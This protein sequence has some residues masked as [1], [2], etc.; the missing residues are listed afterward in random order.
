MNYSSLRLQLLRMMH[1]DQMAIKT[2]AKFRIVTENN[3]EKLKDI[4]FKYGWPTI[5]IVGKQACEAA[6]LIAQHAD[7][8]VVFQKKCLQLI[9]FSLKKGDVPRYHYAYLYDRICANTGSPYQRFGTQIRIDKSKI[10]EPYPPTRLHTKKLDV[11]RR[12][13]DLPPLEEYLF[14]L[15]S[16]NSKK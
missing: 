10:Y 14:E 8:D 1:K 12:R 4:I 9:C 13:Y 2:P 15:K 16:L 3:S 11:L 5:T 7:H 6:W